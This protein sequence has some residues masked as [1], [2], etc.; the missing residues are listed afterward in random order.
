MNSRTQAKLLAQSCWK[1][2]SSVGI[3]CWSCL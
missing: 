1:C 3:I 2:R